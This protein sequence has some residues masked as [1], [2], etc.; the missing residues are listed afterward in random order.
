MVFPARELI[1]TEDVRKRAEQLVGDEPWGREQWE[2]LSEGDCSTAWRA[3]SRGSATT[4]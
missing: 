3:G 2:R 4:G 1:P